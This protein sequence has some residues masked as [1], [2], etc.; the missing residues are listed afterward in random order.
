MGFVGVIAAAA[1]S[2]SAAPQTAS[3][4]DET[5]NDVLR[6]GVHVDRL[7]GRVFTDDGQVL[8]GYLRW[9][10][11]EGS[12]ADMLDGAKELPWAHLR[13][14]ERL[15]EDYARERARERSITV[16][17]VRISWDEDPQ[18]EMQTSPSG[19]R[20]GHLRSLVVVDDARARLRLKSGREVDLVREG[21][22]L[23]RGFR[24][25]VVEIA[26]WDGPGTGG[27]AGGGPA[28]GG[29]AAGESVTGQ[30]RAGASAGTG[31]VG[32]E[33]VAD[34][35]VELR[36]R[37]L[38]RIELMA[39]PVG[40]A[41][42]ASHRLHGTL[43]TRG[44]RELSG[45]VAWDLDEIL[46]SDVLDGEAA[47]EDHSIPFERIAAIERESRSSAR[48][49]LT[50]GR[51]LVLRNSNDVNEQNRGIEV[52]DPGFGR[53]VVD[54]DGFEAV[55]FQ[56]AA[57]SLAPYDAYDGGRE[58]RGTVRSVGGDIVTGTL[59]W[60]NDESFTWETIE[61]VA[62]GVRFSVEIGAVRS[63]E[64]RPE[65][66]VEIELRDGR[67]LRLAGSEDVDRG[68]RGVFVTP[69]GG[70]TVFVRWPDLHSVLIDP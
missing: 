3:H 66:G 8:E 40:V 48:V 29:S 39:P 37:D 32:D 21:T 63:I 53:A 60:D 42:P 36:W 49:I 13:E 10:R 61:G 5:K 22:D 28:R 69:E 25:L 44:G 58:L 35:P 19:V 17:G 70:A 2:L 43:R 64:R 16:G 18:D 24:G 1:L 34:E 47:G 54:W 56:R 68:N 38:D 20:F 59:R 45:F 33:P 57:G 15:D 51:E 23:G 27:M 12:W 62:D 14:A 7:Y 11:N 41:P 31:P 6:N 52:A 30:S 50:D 4:Q 26:G 67:L 46:T 65:R 9:D 55:R